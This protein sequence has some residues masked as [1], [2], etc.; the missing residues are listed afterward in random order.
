MANKP[1]QPMFPL[2]LATEEQ[3]ELAGILNTGVIEHG[4]DA[5]LT[6]PEGNAVDGVPSSIR[7]NA[8]D[9]SFEGF[10]ENGGWLPMGGGGIRWESLPHASTAPLAE[11]RG[12]LVD[13]TTGASTVV[14]PTPT[15]IGDSVTICDAYGKFSVYPLTIDPD[16]NLLYG[17]TEPM[18]I[19]TDSVSATF[20]WSG[21]A[22]GWIITA[23]VGLGQGRVYS[24]TIYTDTLTAETAQITLV[25]KPSII[26]VY[27]DGK[28][29]LDS[30]YSL[31]GNYVNF[32][33]SLASG[34]EVQIIQYIPIQ[35]GVGGTGN[36]TVVSW[37]YRSGSAIGGETTISLDVDAEDVSE[38]YVNGNRK[39]K[40]LKFTYDSVAK[41]INLNEALVAGDELVVIING[42]P[43]LYNQI[44]R[45]PEE[46]ARSTNV[47]LS[48]VI[49]SS[50]TTTTLNGKTVVYDVVAQKIW[51]LPS[52]IPSGASVVSVSGSNLTYAP[53]NVVVSLVARP[54]SS[55]ELKTQIG[56]LIPYTFES[57]TLM[58]QSNRLEAGYMCY[59]VTNEFGH[60][61]NALWKI[62]TTADATTYSRQL[63]SG[64]YANLRPRNVEEYASF[65]FGSTTDAAVN[66]AATTEAHRV[67][68]AKAHM[69]ALVF[70]AGLFPITTTNLM[71]PRRYFQFLGKGWDITTLKYVGVD[72]QDSIC[73]VLDNPN[74]ALTRNHFYQTVADFTID[75]GMEADKYASSV[76]ING[77]YPY[78]RIKSVGHFYANIDANGLVGQM[79]CHTQGRQ[80]PTVPAYATRVGVSF[81]Y[82][83]WDAKGYLSNGIAGQRVV[84]I[85]GGETTL[86]VAAT[87]GSTT[88]TVANASKFRRHFILD[89]QAEG[90]DG[91]AEAIAIS[92]VSGN[93]I[94][95]KLPLARNHPIGSTIVN[96]VYGI[97]INGATMEVGI[98]NVGNSNN[99]NITGCY[100]EGVR[101]EIGGWPRKLNISDNIISETD[102]LIS[103]VN[104]LSEIRYRNNLQPFPL[105]V[106]VRGRDGSLNPQFFDPYNMPLL[107]A[108]G[109]TRKQGAI[110]INETDSVAKNGIYLQDVVVRDVYDTNIGGT[111]M[112]EMEFSG[113]FAVAP[114]AG[115]VTALSLNNAIPA[116]GNFNGYTFEI[117]ARM[118]REAN[119]M[120]GIAH[121]IATAYN[122]NGTV[123]AENK[124]ISALYGSYWNDTTGVR[125]LAGATTSRA[126][127]VC[128][129]EATGTQ[130]TSFALSGKIGY[131]V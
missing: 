45:T 18:T 61:T 36:S 49:L 6:V 101:P 106:N 119:I 23:G 30:K 72:L 9:D 14:L 43:T 42:D 115:N 34:A 124:T 113:L 73:L 13:N 52:G 128:F 131:A 102:A 89:I 92:S 54:N 109:I 10:Y 120:P 32:S 90:G 3:S 114:G 2:G 11:G 68:T 27:V 31:D 77:H 84:N 121:I 15:R 1:T 55:D 63:A 44:D 60:L 111:V 40:L 123:G 99:V 38:L 122:Q 71:V 59:T 127:L 41:Q 75:G 48:Q 88:L 12:Y 100:M 7:Y 50:D 64:L 37:V 25:S 51:G 116:G 83:A 87:A 79:N 81:N 91:V 8:V 82:N 96:S 66:Q 17:S 108:G 86:T 20:T 125:I 47:P 107:D 74:P 94:T 21:E 5:V 105:R 78:V 39:Q 103:E 70:P 24:R 35:L 129:G 93:V 98:L 95:L 67:A 65:G 22:R 97:N 110:S 16:S 76:A 104:R 112:R 126:S 117:S 85:D 57:V 58:L 33:P 29:I 26:D 118:H 56:S 4:P 53:G 46:V 19:S 80:S 130:K 62:D 69:S 28:R